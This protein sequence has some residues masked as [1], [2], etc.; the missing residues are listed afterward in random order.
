MQA[1]IHS[2]SGHY[3]LL[4]G[5]DYPIK[6]NEFILDFFEKNDQHEFIDYTF[7]GPGGREATAFRYERFFYPQIKQH[8]LQLIKRILD[9]VRYALPKRKIPAGLVPYIGATWWNLSGK[10]VEYILGYTNQNSAVMKFYKYTLLADEMFFQTLILNSQFKE[11]VLNENLR[12]IDWEGQTS[13]PNIITMKYLEGLKQSP[14]LFARKFDP[15]IDVE[16]LD[17]LDDFRDHA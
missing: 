10:M 8:R 16:I 5:V 7:M 12:L 14:A 13:H 1:A 15:D 2:H 17:V 6:N 11:R 9:K 4:S 3:V